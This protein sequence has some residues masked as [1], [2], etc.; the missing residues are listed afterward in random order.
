M[1]LTKNLLKKIVLEEMAK[2]GDGREVED[3]S[4]DAEEVEADELANTL[5]KDIDYV[6]ACKV[7]EARLVRRLSRIKENKTRA[8]KKILRKI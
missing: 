4:N 2:F 6:K 7:E 5:E 1:K 3:A 8:I